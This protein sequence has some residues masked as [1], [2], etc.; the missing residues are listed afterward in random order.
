MAGETS[1]SGVVRIDRRDEVELLAAY[2][3]GRP[4]VGDRQ[5]PDTRFATASG[6]KGL[7]ALAVVTLIEDGTLDRGHDGRSRCS[8]ATSRSSTTR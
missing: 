1:F 4:S 6:T 5:H 8:A 3:D 2:G 7:T